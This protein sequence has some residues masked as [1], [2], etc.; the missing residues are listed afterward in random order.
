[1]KGA[2]TTRTVYY[3]LRLVNEKTVAFVSL[4][5]LISKSY[6]RAI[7][8]GQKKPSI[9]LRRSYAKLFKIDENILI[10]FE[11]ID[12]NSKMTTINYLLKLLTAIGVEDI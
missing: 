4:G 11:D 12:K 6:V 9:R 8:T 3:W 5:L 1:M 2:R 7:E 10:E